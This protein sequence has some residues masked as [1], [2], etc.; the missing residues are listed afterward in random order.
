MLLAM[1]LTK[2]KQ[3]LHQLGYPLIQMMSFQQLW[4]DPLEFIWSFHWWLFIWEW[5]T[6]YSMR[7]N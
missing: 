2:S 4:T 6:H 7:N 1:S 3:P 5:L